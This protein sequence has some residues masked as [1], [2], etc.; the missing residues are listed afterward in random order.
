MGLHDAAPLNPSGIAV[1]GSRASSVLPDLL[2]TQQLRHLGSNPDEV[3]NLLMQVRVH[4]RL[5]VCVSVP[6]FSAQVPCPCARPACVRASALNAGT[7]CKSAS[8]LRA[9]LPLT[10]HL[11]WFPL[12]MRAAGDCFPPKHP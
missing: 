9:A 3:S 5:C 10:Q 6:R 7:G 11:I 1:P 2:Q 4:V 8:S 12:L